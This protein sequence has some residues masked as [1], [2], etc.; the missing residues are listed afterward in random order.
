M[1]TRIALIDI[2]RPDEPVVVEVEEL[3]DTTILVSVPNTLVRFQ[4]QRR[5][6]AAWF[7]GSLG[8]R[9]FV[10]DPNKPGKLV[11]KSGSAS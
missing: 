4:L 2:D 7:E 10:F 3:R 11:S 8:G 5:N 1:A 6:G 9:Y